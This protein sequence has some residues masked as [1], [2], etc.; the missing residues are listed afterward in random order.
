MVYPVVL[1]MLNYY[2]DCFLDPVIACSGDEQVDLERTGSIPT[3]PS[4]VV[5]NR[6]YREVSVRKIQRK[7]S[8]QTYARQNTSLV[9]KYYSS[10]IIMEFP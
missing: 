10:K 8:Y 5:Y 2:Y 6:P 4:E 1:S 7:S 3:S 9:C